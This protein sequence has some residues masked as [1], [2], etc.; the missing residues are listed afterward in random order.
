MLL[1]ISFLWLALVTTQVPVHEFKRPLK[2]SQ[3]KIQL[4]L[5]SLTEE[6]HKDAFNECP[7]SPNLDL[8]YDYRMLSPFV[9]IMQ[10]FI[11]MQN[12]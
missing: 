10:N 8:F 4:T 5:T 3:C 12:P 2:V 9:K 7:T 6:S 1:G 11:L